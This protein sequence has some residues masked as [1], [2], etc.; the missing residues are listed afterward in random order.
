LLQVVL[1][2]LK[3]VSIRRPQIFYAV[4]ALVALVVALGFSIGAGPAYHV[5]AQVST[6]D[7]LLAVVAAV[8][9]I[10]FLIMAV[11]LWVLSK[12]A[13][14]LSAKEEQPITKR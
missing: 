14:E 4:P 9:G 1:S 3:H 5:N 8:I 2:T 13:G 6:D 10:A 12:V 7:M 11:M